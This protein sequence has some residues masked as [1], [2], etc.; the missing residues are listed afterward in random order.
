M[1]MD[2]LINLV[3]LL[4]IVA[5]LLKRVKEITQKGEEVK[6]VPEGPPDPLAE[7]IKE[8][9]ERSEMRQDTERRSIRDVFE[10]SGHEQP[11]ESPP[12][13]ETPS[14]PPTLEDIFKRL[15]GE[16]APESRQPVPEP[17]AVEPPPPEPVPAEPLTEPPPISEYKPPRQKAKPKARTGGLSFDGPEVVR[18]IILSEILGPP[19]SLR[20]AP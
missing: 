12:V 13:T 8:A 4:V 19:V 1:N 15:A 9:R 2:V 14:A 17:M 7:T 11:V 10:E 16:I 3:I 5:S 6:R 20:E 18:G